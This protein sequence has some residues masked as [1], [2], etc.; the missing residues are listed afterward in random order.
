MRQLTRRGFTAAGILAVLSLGSATFLPG[1]NLQPT[2]YGPP[3]DYDPSTNEVEDV[4]GPPDDFDPEENEAVCVYGPPEDFGIDEESDE[5]DG[6]AQSEQYAVS[7][8][9]GS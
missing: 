2:V 5:D 4:Y 1:C 8:E 9:A 6:E 7:P 3:D